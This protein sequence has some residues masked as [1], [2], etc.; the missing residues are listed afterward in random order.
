VLPVEAP[1]DVAITDAVPDDGT[2]SVAL[3]R[4]AESVVVSDG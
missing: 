4:P 2:V 3:A 1:P